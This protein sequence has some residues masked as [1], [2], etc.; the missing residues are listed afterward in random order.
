LKAKK[1]II[2][3]NIK[4]MFTL[5]D[6]NTNITNLIETNLVGELKR[7]DVRNFDVISSNANVDVSLSSNIPIKE[8]KI[9]SNQSKINDL[10]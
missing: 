8:F 5:S 1:G 7:E 10:I 4:P 2:F 3:H 9:E 6:K